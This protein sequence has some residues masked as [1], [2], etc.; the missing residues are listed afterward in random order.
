MLVLRGD[1][2]FGRTGTGEDFSMLRILWHLSA[3]NSAADLKLQPQV[4]RQD[5]F[6]AAVRIFDIAALKQ[7]QDN[8]AD[9]IMTQLCWGMEQFRSWLDRIRRAG[10]AMP[11][12]DQAS[13][14]QWH[15][16]ATPV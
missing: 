6:P 10:V 8:G 13:A 5:T 4:L 1:L 15:C 14:I 11:V 2:P 12:P 7:K 3:E 16:P 9:C